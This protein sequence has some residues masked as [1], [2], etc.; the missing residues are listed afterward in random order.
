MPA[1][2]GGPLPRERALASTV[3]L[4]CGN[5]LVALGVVVAPGMVLTSLSAIGF[6][7]GISGGR[8]RL[9]VRP[10][11]VLYTHCGWDLATLSGASSEL[12]QA[13]FQA[14][15]AAAIGPFQYPLAGR[16]VAAVVRRAVRATGAYNTQLFG[17]F[18]LAA[19][20]QAG[21]PIFDDHGRI[22]A[23]VGH[24]CIDPRTGCA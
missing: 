17:V 2:H 24:A 23:I 21:T 22:A 14:A 18:Q 16:M 8:S 7:T 13:G 12:G 10:L 20:P 19:A 6:G 9:Q 11:S 1:K 5:T 3:V 4:Y 15:A